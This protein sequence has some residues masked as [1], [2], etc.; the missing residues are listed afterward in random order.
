MKKNE[1]TN[2][3][4][5]KIDNLPYTELFNFNY[6][7]LTIFLLGCLSSGTTYF[8]SMILDDFGIKINKER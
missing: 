6:D 5:E 2:G 1:N 4:K 3:H 7:V 8:I